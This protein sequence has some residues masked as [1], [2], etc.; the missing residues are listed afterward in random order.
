MVHLYHNTRDG[1][2]SR[3]AKQWDSSIKLLVEANKQ[4]LVTFL[5]PGATFEKELNSEMQSRVLEADLSYVVNWSGT[6]V[7]LHVEF[8]KRRDG[9][10]GRR[11]WKYNAQA[12]IITDLPVYSFVV[13]LRRDGNVVQSPYKLPFPGKEVV[14]VFFFDTIKL[15]EIPGA[16]LKQPG[17]EGL[18][19]LLPLTQDGVHR[20]VVDEMIAS[21]DHAWKSDLLPLAYA[22]ASLVFK[23]EKDREWLRKR[24]TMLSD[25]ILE[26]SWAYQEMVAKGVAK[27]RQKWLHEGELQARRDAVLDIVQDRFPPLVTLISSHIQN[28]E[29]TNL[30]R[31]LIVKLSAAQTPQEAEQTFRSL[32]ND[33]Q[34]H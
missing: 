24:F 27:G 8:Q 21:L 9:D 25:D 30:L 29:D 26:D 20:E 3:M 17:M 14:P 1:G 15:W 4:D 7:V 22:F 28:I 6:Q 16:F 2:V 12:T 33:A 18:L 5:L 11:L 31:R 19:P 32:V 23:N 13:Y 34:Q 10:M